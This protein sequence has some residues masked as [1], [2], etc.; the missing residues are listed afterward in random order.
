[1][2]ADG[3]FSGT[4]ELGTWF[5]SDLGWKEVTVDGHMTPSMLRELADYV[6]AM[7]VF[8]CAEGDFRWR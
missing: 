7:R 2:N 8:R 4:G 3:H 1:V 6:E 5:S